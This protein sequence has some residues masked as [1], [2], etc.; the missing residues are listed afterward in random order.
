M[1][2][3]AG[4]E[5]HLREKEA[6]EARLM[7]RY[8]NLANDL[9]AQQ[10]AEQQKL[11]RAPRPALTPRRGGP[12]GAGGARGTHSGASPRALATGGSVP[13]ARTPRGAQRPSPR[14][15]VAGATPPTH[16]RS[17]YAN[18]SR[19]PRSGA[20]RAALVGAAA[21]WPAAGGATPGTR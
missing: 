21:A 4:R 16:A 15:R 12:S 19:T 1:R 10:R 14:A 13:A 20:E 2:V 7:L 8:K 3:R 17:G 6:D 11:A 9:D 5:E 18:G